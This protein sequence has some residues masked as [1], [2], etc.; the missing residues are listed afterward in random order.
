MAGSPLKRARRQAAGFA[1]A[2]RW[3]DRLTGTL[4]AR[5]AGVAAPAP[6]DAPTPPEVSRILP[7]QPA[8]SQAAY[9]MI[10]A[11]VTLDGQRVDVVIGIP[12][13]VID[14]LAGDARAGASPWRAS[15]TSGVAV[16]VEVP[17]G[18]AQKA[19]NARR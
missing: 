3:Q 18:H 15:F 10:R 8:A 4:M 11:V 9:Q 6:I 1:T 16:R 14:A 19:T 2:E 12:A 13:K 7:R 17:S 5:P